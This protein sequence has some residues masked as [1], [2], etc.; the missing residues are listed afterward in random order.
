VVLDLPPLGCVNVHASLLPRWRGA[1]PIQAAILNGD[2]QTGATIM[3]MDAGVDTGAILSQRPL[4][5]EPG[6]TAETL[7]SRLSVLGAELLV[8]TLPDYIIGKVIP[9][10][11]VDELATRAAMI[12]KEDGLLDF[13]LPAV[14]LERRVRAFTPWP[15]TYFIRH[16][17]PLKVL[18]ASVVPDSDVHAGQESTIQKFPAIGT[19]QGWLVLDEVQPAG[20]KPMPGD[21]FLRGAHSWGNSK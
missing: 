4:N 19:S 8:Q 6:D 12:Q 15:G 13:S 18:V 16:D 14:V 11:Q 3:K 1:A 21:V 20:K 5:I 7:S 9:Q 10:A 17:G 2:A